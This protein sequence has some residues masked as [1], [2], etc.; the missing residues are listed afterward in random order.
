MGNSTGR[1]VHVNRALANVA[2]A[3]KP[4]GMIADMLAPIVPVQKQS[5][6]YTIWSRAEVY[7]VEEDQ[8]GPG[9]ITNKVSRSAT[10]ATYFCR[11]Y[12][13]GDTIP[14]EDID[15]ADAGW[16]ITE[17]NSRVE[18]IMDKLHLGWEKRVGLQMTSGTNVG[19]YTAVASAWTDHTAGNSDPIGDINTRLQSMQD[20]TGV[21]PNRIVMGHQLWRHFRE[22]ADVIDRIY[23]NA[24]TQPNARLVTARNAAALFEVDEFLIGGAYY[25]AADEGQSASLTA[26]WADHVLVYYAPMTPQKNKPSFM[27]TFR[28]TKGMPM[29]AYNYYDQTRKSDIIEAGYYQDEKI[30]ASDLAQLLT[31]CTSSS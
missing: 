6:A 2:I 19:S 4:E 31:N 27:Y 5:D 15:N 12:A 1:D 16:I 3:Y 28:W 25:N 7:K 18:Y 21:R 9:G 13:L 29:Q 23:G 11:N 20:A 14:Q 26:I 17:R 24:G 8:R 30:T 10:S 22:H